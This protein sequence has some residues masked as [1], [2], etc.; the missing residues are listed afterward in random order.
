MQSFE[1]FDILEENVDYELV[2]SD[3]ENW[4]VRMLQGPFPETVIQF[5]ELKMTDED[6]TLSFNFN[7][8]TTP[9]PSLREDMVEVQRAAAAVLNSILATAA[10][11]ALENG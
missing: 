5:S 11:T 3:G 4:D 7:I 9:D 10:R 8:V 1:N 2:P 6:G